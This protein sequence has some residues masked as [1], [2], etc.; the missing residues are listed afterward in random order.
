[1]IL[2]RGPALEVPRADLQSS[3]DAATAQP[4]AATPEAIE[5]EPILWVLHA[6]ACRAR[7]FTTS[8]AS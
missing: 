5:P 6:P 3:P 7:C 8:C 4:D 2:S 1:M